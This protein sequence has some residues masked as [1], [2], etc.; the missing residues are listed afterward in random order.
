MISTK[1]YQPC[2]AKMLFHVENEKFPEMEA[3]SAGTPWPRLASS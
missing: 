2:S 3:A 1:K